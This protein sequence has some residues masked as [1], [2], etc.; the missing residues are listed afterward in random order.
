MGIWKRRGLTTAFVISAGLFL[1]A[2]VQLSDQ[3][4]RAFSDEESVALAEETIY[5]L[6]AKDEDRLRAMV[7]PVAQDAFTSE[8]IE[9]IFTYLPDA[10]DAQRYLMQ[11][12]WNSFTTPGEETTQSFDTVFRLDFDTSGGAVSRGEF[13]EIQL[14][15]RGDEP[16]QVT[17]VNIV[18]T[19]EP[20]YDGLAEWPVSFW[21]AVI[22][23][24]LTALFCI[25]AIV[26]VWR[27]KQLKRRVLWTLFILLI[28][29]PVF[30]FT[31]TT[32][33]W[34]LWS[35]G[36]QGSDGFVRLNIFN[37]K[38][39]SAAWIQ[40]MFTGH[41]VIQVAMP[42][43]AVLF[44]IQK[45]RGKLVLKPAKGRSEADGREPAPPSDPAVS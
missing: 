30:A 32:G 37:F 4:V 16:L 39:L 18:P 21:I 27:T 35:P 6:L 23:A 2:C 20:V 33:D 44:F 3:L 12:H 22:L 40:D 25:A 41:H 38:V 15:A 8:T 14:F 9:Q 17:R 19:P 13:F 45:A 11:S 10:P 24:P 5:A 34:M 28:G 7:H 29:Y 42:I 31:T 26:A 1:S 36:I 43:G